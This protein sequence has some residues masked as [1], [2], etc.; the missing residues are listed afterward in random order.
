MSYGLD[1]REQKQRNMSMQAPKMLGNTWEF[2]GGY[3]INQIYGSS[4]TMKKNNKG[5]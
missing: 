2:S 5:S 3:L 4:D 1:E